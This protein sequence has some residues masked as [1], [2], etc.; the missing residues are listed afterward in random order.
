MVRSSSHGRRYWRCNIEKRKT[1]AR[2]DQTPKGKARYKRARE[3]R[4]AAQ[5]R[6]MEKH[7]ET[8]AGGVR[9]VYRIDP[10]RKQE[11]VSKLKDKRA[12][13]RAEMEAVTSG[14]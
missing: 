6:Y 3:A 12:E 9:L 8:H 7:I 1:D 4:N 2:Y 10:A 14:R 5:R 11:L 13:Q